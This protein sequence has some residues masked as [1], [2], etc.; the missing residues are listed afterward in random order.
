M[1]QERCGKRGGPRGAL[2]EE[3][4]GQ[5]PE[6]EENKL[7]FSCFVSVVRKKGEGGVLSKYFS[8]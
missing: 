2:T 3:G 5:G 4:A 7:P 8:S 6:P 1:A